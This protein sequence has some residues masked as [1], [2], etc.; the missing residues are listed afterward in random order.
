MPGH[1]TAAAREI[2]IDRFKEEGRVLSKLS[3]HPNIVRALDFG[4]AEGKAD[5][6]PYLV[7][8]WLEGETLEAMI[9]RRRTAGG[10]ATPREALRVMVPVV[11]ALAFAHRLGI[12]H[13]DIKPANIFLAGTA[14]GIVPK[15]LDFGIAKAMQEGETCTQLA[16]RTSSG[17]HAFSPPH[18]APEQFRPKAFGPTGPW[19]DVHGAGLLLCELLTGRPV[20]DGDD[21][22]DF[23]VAS[24]SPER[25]T[26][27]SRGVFVS[28]ALERVCARATATQPRDRFRDATEMQ[29]AL[30]AC[31]AE[32]GAD[33]PPPA[34][35]NKT[36]PAEPIPG[37]AP[38]TEQRG[39][40]PAPEQRTSAPFAEHTADRGVSSTIGRFAPSPAKRKPRS[41]APIIVGAAVAA[42]VLGVGGFFLFSGGSK[43]TKKTKSSAS[44]SDEAAK[45]D[46]ACKAADSAECRAACDGGST[47]ACAREGDAL[48]S[49][50]LLTNE[51]WARGV[52]VLD[53]AC[54]AKH[55]GACADLAKMLRDVRGTPDPKRA[56]AVAQMACDGGD[57][58]GCRRLAGHHVDGIATARDRA[59][60]TAL[61]VRACDGG[62]R[63]ACVDL[64]TT[65]MSGPRAGRDPVKA[66]S[67]LKPHCDAGEQAACVGL[68]WHHLTGVGVPQDLGAVASL[69]KSACELGD[70]DGCARFGTQHL[71]GHGA[72]KDD[73][74]AVALYQSACD[75][76]SV[77]G[78]IELANAH[79]NGLGGLA[80]DLEPALSLARRGC[81][82]GNARACV[83][84]AHY[85]TVK[86]EVTPALKDMED[87]CRAGEWLACTSAARSHLRGSGVARDVQV[88]ISLV[89]RGCELGDDVSCSIQSV[90]Y[91]TGE[92][93][94]K[95]VTRGVS[96]AAEACGQGSGHGCANSGWAYQ[97]GAGVPKDES[98]AATY[99]DR[100]C[101]MGES[102]GCANYASLRYAQDPPLSRKLFEEACAMLSYRACAT[103]GGM[104]ERGHGGLKNA[105]RAAE[106]YQLACNDTTN[107]SN[108]AVLGCTELAR[109]HEQGIGVPKNEVTAKM[110]YAKA[111]KLYF[112]TPEDK[113]VGETACRKAK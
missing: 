20:F 54:N 23:F 32:S 82:T 26:P 53:V 2:L 76:G 77:D 24:T 107:F 45:A 41:K 90:Y 87:A 78:C 89:Q 48:A 59:K 74:K 111:C 91:R 108:S 75:S 63:A 55:F 22:G 99:Y 69:S 57:L 71:R 11:G 105:S 70:G 62:L 81:A 38:L 86:G 28:D 79:M 40:A 3:E 4:V 46:A 67:L 52:K 93:L 7:L 29:D 96:M 31:A 39:S 92:G 94:P 68:A 103:A 19:T 37:A 60:G 34:A 33:A 101:K 8:E 112:G 43:T 12:A 10:A 95:D 30:L 113:G 58:D 104:Y 16:T 15:V 44:A 102:L 5:P 51:D 98:R 109:L 100:A 65:L 42:G 17:F 25:A 13:R 56:L 64:A 14:A 106:L 73:A 97:Y 1:F 66:V 47:T 80:R 6:I 27:R 83:A 35:A 21:H 36:M 88:G 84:L 85:R 49:K 18:G 72:P 61:L 110:L 50:R 9:A